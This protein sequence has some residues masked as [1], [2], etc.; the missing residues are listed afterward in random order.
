[1]IWL[2]P[3]TMVWPGAPTGSSYTAYYSK[4]GVMSVTT[5]GVTGADNSA[6]I[7]LTVGALPSALATQYP[8]YANATTLTLPSTLPAA[9]QSL[10]T[11]Q[12]VVTQ[13]QGSA[14]TAATQVQLGPIL[15]AQ[16]GAN[17][18]TASLGVSFASGTGIPTFRLWAPTAQG[19]SLNLYT[20]AT[21]GQANTLPM[22][23]DSN[24]GI[25]S[26]S[27]PDATLVNV[28]YYTYSV[29]VYARAASTSGSVVTNTVTD[30]YSVSLS[31]NSLRS[32]IVDLTQPATQPSGWPGV[33]IPTSATP[34]DSVIYELHLRDFSVNDSSVPVA[35]QGKFLAFTDTSSNG[36]KNLAQLANA[37]LTHIHLLPAFD[38][39][40][41]DEL[42]CTNPVIRNS[43]GA[44]T[45]AETDVKATQGTD[46]YNWGYDPLHYGAPEGSYSSA[47][48]NG[49]ARVLEFRQMVQSLHA[50]GLRVVMD[51]VYNHTYAA[52]QDAH[53]IL[54][55]VVPG[56][57]HRLDA[58]GNV[59]NYSCCADTATER[60]MMSKLMT[61]TLVRWSQYYLVDG[62]RFDILGMLSKSAVLSARSAVEAVTAK[63]ARGHTYFYG[64][65]WTPNSAVSAVVATATQT[66]TAG[67]GIGTFN[68]RIRD[69]VRGGSPF[70]TGSAMV[71]NQGFINGQCYASNSQVGS[72]STTQ[73]T[74]ALAATDLI[75]VSLAGNLA[76]F[77]L[78]SGVTGASLLSNG[79]PA[80]YT[81]SPQENIAYISV[82]DNETLFDVSQYKQP[83]ALSSMDRARAQAVGLSLVILSQGVPFIH[84]G[85][86]GL[87]S[88]SGDSNSYN[89]GDYFN[90]IDWTRQSNYW[91]TGLPPDNT[92]NNAANVSTLTPLLNNL[93]SPDANSMATSHAAVL[94]FLNIRKSTDLFRL[95][96]ASDINNCLS[97]PDA[98]APQVGVIVMRI[99]GMGCVS[100]TAS[101]Y[102][103]VLVIFN[104]SATT[105]TVS[106]SAYANRSKGS[107]STN[108]S[109]HPVQLAGAD[110]VLQAGWN[111]SSTANG[112]NFV[113]PA[114]TTAVFVEYP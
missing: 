47:P 82:H 50:T 16:Y 112:G 78:R 39:A 30:P 21:G 99:Q 98:T 32:M 38:F 93:S 76:S 11:Y 23:F 44:G 74:Q 53:S 108:L 101:G 5:T 104:A 8:Q 24:T 59:E 103:S 81:Q 64:E 67:T 35:H 17:A 70:D 4:S 7:A 111:F 73:Q 106:V 46:C 89:S 100:N 28:G 114:R 91:A 56:Y 51:V 18:Q 85:D 80:G 94:D 110:T 14:V 49:L 102:K 22:S 92:G 109:L 68:D 29:T 3:Q 61:D 10:L 86:D 60:T 55:R 87:R 54:D 96:Q 107:A 34:T 77:P 1:V 48:D 13:S 72:C 19:V 12:W 52:G 90:R 65:G 27:A 25:W 95:G 58:N 71:T 88:K 79:Q 26:V 40:T 31:G 41:V 84:G 83:S 63:D 37:G 33:L 62:F 75:R 43:T 57:Y 69:A 20:Q 15:D 105:Q 113:V 97:F 2:T 6:G 66:S 42:A 9:I 45:E 36:M